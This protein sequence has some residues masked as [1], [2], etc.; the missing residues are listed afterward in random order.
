MWD[1]AIIFWWFSRR[2]RATEDQYLSP[3]NNERTKPNTERGTQNKKADLPDDNTTGSP[4]S[5]PRHKN[6]TFPTPSNITEQMANDTCRGAIQR[7]NIYEDCLNLTAVDTD[8]YVRSCV[9]D[10]KV[11]LCSFFII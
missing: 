3:G 7:T 8:H 1:R 11:T 2:K 6:K 10:I 9:E 4:P 5:S